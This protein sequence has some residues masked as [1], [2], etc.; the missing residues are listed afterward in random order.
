MDLLKRHRSAARL[1][2]AALWVGLALGGCDYFRPDEPPPP[3]SGTV[4]VPDYSSPDRSLT[5]MAQ[6]IQLGNQTGGYL[7]A[8]ADSTQPS[9]QE[10]NVFFD[11]ADVADVQQGTTIPSRWNISP[12][13]SGFYADLITLPPAGANP[14][15]TFQDI[16]GQPD[17][18]GTEQQLLHRRYIYFL[19]AGDTLGQGVA[20]LRFV[21]RSGSDWKLI[22]WIDHR[23]AAARPGIRTFGYLRLAGQ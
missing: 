23:D 13:E 21:R 15:M 4:F 6:A 16:S 2:A 14:V 8:L 17:S 18:T 12:L 3:G 7:G 9:E 1:A 20:D 10:F 19:A 5:T 22:H 11:L